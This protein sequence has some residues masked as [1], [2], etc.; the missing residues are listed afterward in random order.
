MSAFVELH[1]ISIIEPRIGIVMEY[2]EKGNL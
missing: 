1:F 2:C